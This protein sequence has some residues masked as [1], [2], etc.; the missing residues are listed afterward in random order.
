LRF[1][2]AATRRKRLGILLIVQVALGACAQRSSDE[3]DPVTLNPGM[4]SIRSAAT[5]PARP[6]N[7][8][9][10]VRRF[11]ESCRAGDVAT[12]ISYLT[13]VPPPER[14]EPLMDRL[15]GLSGERADVRILEAREDR[16]AAV[17]VLW[18][19]P[20]RATIDLDPVYLLQEGGSWRILSGL[21]SYERL[22]LVLTDDERASLDRLSIWYKS[23]SRELQLQLRSR[24]IPR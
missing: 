10:V 2:V 18:E 7:P 5:T 4:E 6:E 21:A 15:R 23:R 1:D 9:E 22:A 13:R 17:V 20:G 11:F 16:P 14:R 3:H 19:Q 24:E 8:A 12:A